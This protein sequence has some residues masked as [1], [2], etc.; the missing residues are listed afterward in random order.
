MKTLKDILFLLL[1]LI[2]TLIIV[3]IYITLAGISK[4]NWTIIDPIVGKTN[5]P[6]T[7]I[8]YFSEGFYIGR[9]NDYGYL[10]NEYSQLKEKDKFRV[11]LI[12]DSFV[13]GMQ[14]FTRHHF[15]SLMEKKLNDGGENQVQVLNFGK[16]IFDFNDMYCYYKNFVSQFNP[17]IIYL[18]V[19]AKDF[20]ESKKEIMPEVVLQGDSLNIQFEFLHGKEY[21]KYKNFNVFMKSSIGRLA[22]NC[23]KMM[24]NAMPILFGKFY[25][26]TE[27]NWKMD[28]ES[29]RLSEI[30]KK[31]IEDLG[32]SKKFVIVYL[33]SFPDNL[34]QEIIKDVDVVELSPI[35]DKMKE[36]G[37]DPFYWKATNKYG[38][39]NHEGHKVVADFLSADLAS[40]IKTMN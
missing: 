20:I 32:Q 16:G 10:G 12:G 34:N 23:Y 4:T 25:P 37:N 19:A 14:V 26:V 39:I 33:E 24:D 21:N 17:D 6:D 13:E 28:Y 27:S 38:H 18:F 36:Q 40:R 31:I 9:I 22:F 15:M 30:Q 5:K 2:G 8:I 7:D 1:G 29:L 35:F 11:A 3:E